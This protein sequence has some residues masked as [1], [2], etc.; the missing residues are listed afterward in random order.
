MATE[1]PESDAAAADNVW[2]RNARR[3]GL[4]LVAV[5]AI[6]VGAAVAVS[7]SDDDGGPTRVL[8]APDESPVEVG[9]A[10]PI[11]TGGT[12]IDVVVD[13]DIDVVELDDHDDRP[14]R[15]RPRL[16]G[17]PGRQQLVHA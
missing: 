11:V 4:T 8:P 17:R 15:R 5:L 3:N 13:I 1:P 12:V 9:T 6:G 14:T 7:A 16:P 2:R 10:A